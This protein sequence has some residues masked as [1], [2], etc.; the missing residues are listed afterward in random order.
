MANTRKFKK[1]FRG[2]PRNGTGGS[3]ARASG[4]YQKT[5]TYEKSSLLATDRTSNEERFEATRLA[6]QIDEKMG[7]VRYESGPKRVGWLINMHSVCFQ[8]KLFYLRSGICNPN[9]SET[10]DYA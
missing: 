6:N 7:F 8:A 1:E 5:K 4:R 9:L 10:V 2:G 3:G